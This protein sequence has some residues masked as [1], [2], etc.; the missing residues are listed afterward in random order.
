MNDRARYAKENRQLWYNLKRRVER[1][2]RKYGYDPKEIS[3]ILKN[4]KSSTRGLSMEQLE[5]QRREILYMEGLKT[6]HMKS[7][8]NYLR[9]EGII[10]NMDEDTLQDFWSI[11]NK[12]VVE[13]QLF[14]KM[15][16]EVFEEIE[17]QLN[18]PNSS[19]MSND[20][21]AYRVKVKVTG[22]NQGNILINQGLE[23]DEQSDILDLFDKG[24]E[25]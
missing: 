16:Y 13:N 25:W 4:F 19:G 2:K 21:I 23:I 11:Y 18:S 22:Q 3:K 15:K 24:I 6:T 9:F 8:R 17:S 5:R 12:L 14:E 7:F 1:I 20:E 10:K